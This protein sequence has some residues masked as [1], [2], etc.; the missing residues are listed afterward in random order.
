MTETPTSPSYE[1]FYRQRN[2]W[3][4]TRRGRLWKDYT[5][6]FG[7]L[8][9]GARDRR[10]LD[11][12]CADGRLV[13]FLREQGFTHVT[14]V[15]R[16]AALIGR[17]RRY[18]D[19][20]FICADATDFLRTGRRF[21][22]VFL[23]NLI[24][25]FP[26]DQLVEFMTLLCRALEPGGFAVVRCPNMSHIMAAGHLADDLTHCTGLTEQSLGQLAQLAGFSRTVLLDQFRMQNAKGK[27]KALLSWPLHHYLWWLRGGTRPT[28]I[29]RNLYAQFIK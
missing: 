7:P 15:D 11:L 24:E 17:A 23:L 27:L 14:G 5:R 16:D 8:L 20:E 28:V 3:D 26:R 9:A 19:A 4:E 21:D 2:P 10:V 29:Y 22:I 12:G 13:A 6:R 1:R 25:H 18:S